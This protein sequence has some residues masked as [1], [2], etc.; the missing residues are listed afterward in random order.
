ME[1]IIWSRDACNYCT[2]AKQLL[3]SRS[4]P[5]EE[6]KIGYGYDRDDLLA[7]IPTAKTMPQII[8]N[9][10]PIGGYTELKEILG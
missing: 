1:V 10:D 7:I 3:D 4:I 2:L 8:I 9:G 6:R 5:Y